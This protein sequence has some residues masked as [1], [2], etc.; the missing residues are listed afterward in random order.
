[1]NAVE[2]DGLVKELEVRLDQLKALYD[3]YFQGMERLPPTKKRESIERVLKELRRDQPRNT[4]ARFRFQTLWQRW[5][6][7]TTH[8][9][10]ICRQIEEGTYKRDVLRAQRRRQRRAEPDRKAAP[11]I[12]V[13][14]DLDDFDFDAE[15]GAALEGLRDDK[16]DPE[17]AIP[18]SA[19]SSP[20][21]RAMPEAPRAMPAAPA[22]PRLPFATPAQPT[23]GFATFS[24]PKEASF[25]RPPAESRPPQVGAPRMATDRPAAPSVA[26]PRHGA[27]RTSMAPAPSARPAAPAR[28]T[29]S[30]DLGE[31]DLRRIHAQYVAAGGGSMPYEKLAKQIKTMEPE[32]KKKHGGKSIDFEV[33]VKDGRVGLKPV[34]RG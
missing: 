26:A 15:V 20:S 33:V 29:P 27:E 16:T 28:P 19:P 9:D 3:Q 1:M 6:T 34:T 32:L 30:T 2:F 8:W 10:R 31:R 18:R 13:E 25:K 7:M 5:V 22:G 23:S 24:R 17:I 4:A 21:V 14:V 12:D 11:E